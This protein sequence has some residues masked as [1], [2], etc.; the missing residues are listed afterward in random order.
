[1]AAQVHSID[2]DDVTPEQ[3]NAAKAVN[4]GLIYGQTPFGLARTLGI[5]RTE[6]GDFIDAYYARYPRIRAFMDQCIER[7]RKLGYAQ[8]LL[9]RRRP[10]DQLKSRNRQQV[11]LGERLAVNTVVQGTAAELIK[12]AMIDIH[13]QVT[14][15]RRN[16]KMLIQVHDELV[17]ESPRAEAAVH[18]EMIRDGMVSAIALNVP[19]TVDIG[20]GDNWLDAK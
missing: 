11:A 7:A 18:I 6:A 10:I 4:F 5:S 20:A 1:V 8:T 16:L 17:F 15:E 13:R 2:I 3:R 14:K 12:R 9:G 19:I